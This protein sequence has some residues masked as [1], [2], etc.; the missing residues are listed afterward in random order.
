MPLLQVGQW[1]GGC[2]KETSPWVKYILRLLILYSFG[3]SILKRYWYWS[4]RDIDLG[5]T[6]L[7]KSRHCTCSLVRP[8]L[9]WAAPRWNTFRGRKR[10][11]G[12]WSFRRCRDPFCANAKGSRI[13]SGGHL[14]RWC[15]WIGLRTRSRRRFRL[16]VRTGMV[17]FMWQLSFFSIFA[18]FK[19]CLT[20]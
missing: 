5:K 1:S 7:I 8:F 16:Q 18:I 17:T 20:F 10:R 6:C 19:K 4:Q 14:F 11:L 3:S 15:I 9:D 2:G 13:Q 12:G